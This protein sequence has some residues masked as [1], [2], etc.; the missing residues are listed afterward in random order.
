MGRILTSHSHSL[1]IDTVMPLSRWGAIGMSFC[2]GKRQPFA[3]S[4]CWQRDLELDL[5]AVQD[6]GA[7]AVVTLIEMHEHDELGVR[8][9]PEKTWGL[10]MEWIPLPIPDQQAPGEGFMDRW[11]KAGRR[12]VSMMANGD[13][14][15]L[16][17]KGGLGRTGTVAACLL[18]ESGMAP[19]DAVVATRRARKGAIETEDQQRF[20]LEYEPRLGT[21]EGATHAG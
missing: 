5:R 19:A 16:H 7:K 4:G 9:L 10:G 12:I 15:F 11:P 21:R 18:V 20:V 13:K 1:R 6:W 3:T 2:P 17:C 8:D 14:V